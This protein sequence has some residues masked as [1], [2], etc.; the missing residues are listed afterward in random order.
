MYLLCLPPR[1][2]ITRFTITATTTAS[3]RA[4]ATARNESPAEP[5]RRSEQRASVYTSWRRA[6]EG[7]RGEEED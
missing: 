1:P 6:S 5:K 4:R 7:E 2:E 3:E